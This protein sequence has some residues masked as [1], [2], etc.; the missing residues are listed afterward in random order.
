M[1]IDGCQVMWVVIWVVIW[2]VMWGV[3]LLG[4]RDVGGDQRHDRYPGRAHEELRQ[5]GTRTC[6]QYEM[7]DKRQQDSDAKYRKRLLPA[8]D[9]R[10]E[11]LPFQPTPVLR[12][13]SRH[14]VCH[15]DE[16]QDAIR[17]EIGLVVRVECVEQPCRKHVSERREASCHRHHKRKS[18]VGD[19]EINRHPRR[20]N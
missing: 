17:G 15:H 9:H 16:M 12:Y 6:H 3:L 2:V 11:D 8:Y 13:K 18:Q 1:S 5:Q 19:R 7:A 10:L 14:E 20:L 4:P